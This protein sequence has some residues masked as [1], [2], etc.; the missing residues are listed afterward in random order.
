MNCKTVKLLPK[1]LFRRNVCDDFSLAVSGYKESLGQ[2][3]HHK[4]PL[5]GMQQ[6]QAGWRTRL[7]L[8]V[9]LIPLAC[10]LA[11]CR[12]NST[13]R[14]PDV[15]HSTY[16]GRSSETIALLSGGKKKNVNKRQSAK[17]KC[18]A[19]TVMPILKNGKQ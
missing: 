13:S 9:L 12:L 3:Q 5:K 17:C 2:H 4:I 11:N 10:L 19:A 1:I 8:G 6:E 7:P 16:P 15:S 18:S 14:H